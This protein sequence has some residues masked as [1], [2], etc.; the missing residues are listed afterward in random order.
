MK[1]NQL[2]K[3]WLN[4]KSFESDDLNKSYKNGDTP[5][6]VASREG[7]LEIVKELLSL[8]VDINKC[9][10]DNTNALWASCFANSI[11]V[12][13]ELIANGININNQNGNGATALI[14][15]SSA[16]KS[17]IVKALLDAKADK[18]L[19]TLDDFTALELASNVEIMKLL[20]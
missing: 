8:K 15:S 1:M 14:Y 11:D 2:L 7:N 17:D 4:E 6:I 13:K 5:L 3:E 20:R 12:I 18:S 9:N 16:G 10:N 19:K